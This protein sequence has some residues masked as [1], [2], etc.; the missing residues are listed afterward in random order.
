[1]RVSP[2]V[3]ESGKLEQTLSRVGTEGGLAAF[4]SGTSQ[5][6]FL[7]SLTL[8]PISRQVV[9]LQIVY[10]ERIRIRTFR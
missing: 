9:E 5:E 10:G 8:T 2:G 3:E 6:I 4:T 7:A 1:M